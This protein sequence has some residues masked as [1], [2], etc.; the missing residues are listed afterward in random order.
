[1]PWSNGSGNRLHLASGILNVPLFSHETMRKIADFMCQRPATGDVLTSR[2]NHY[3]RI[4]LL[5]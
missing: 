1:M 2:I 4:L 3:W 5:S